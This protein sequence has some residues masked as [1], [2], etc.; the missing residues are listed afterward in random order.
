[1]IW[2]VYETHCSVNSMI[3][4]GVRKTSLADPEDDT[5]YLGS[6]VLLKQMIRSYGVNAF[7]KRIIRQFDNKHDAYEL[8]KQIVTKEFLMQ[9][10]VINKCVGGRGGYL[11][12]IAK[13][14]RW[15]IDKVKLANAIEKTASYRRGKTKRDDVGLLR[16]SK[17]LSG[18]T[19]ETHEYLLKMSEKLSGRTKETHDGLAIMAE[20]NKVTQARRTKETCSGRVRQSEKMIGALNV[21][22]RNN[23]TQRRILTNV[24]NNGNT[25]LLKRYDK[26]LQLN[27]LRDFSSGD[28]R[29]SVSTKYNM[30]LTT[31]QRLIKINVANGN[32]IL[33]EEINKTSQ[34]Y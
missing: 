30:P 15:Q 6:G 8:E 20:K 25:A 34:S 24:L 29:I 32:P 10:N 23:D 16:M 3:Y 26:E 22:A 33:T 2:Y 5:S 19:K 9:E 21:S 18:R 31:L 7:T 4:V 1:M 17:A 14:K 27:C 28:E 12:F 11:E 13:E